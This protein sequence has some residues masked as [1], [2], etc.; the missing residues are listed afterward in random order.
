MNQV[1]YMKKIFVI[2]AIAALMSANV[3]SLWKNIVPKLKFLDSP[4]VK[5]FS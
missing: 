1:V 3:F 5:G 2:S 4:K